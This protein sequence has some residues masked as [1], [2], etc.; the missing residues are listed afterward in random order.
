MLSALLASGRAV[1]I[2]RYSHVSSSRQTALPRVVCQADDFVLRKVCLAISGRLLRR[3]AN[4]DVLTDGIFL[5]PEA[6]RGGFADHDDGCICLL[7]LRA[8]AAPARDAQADRLEIIRG[9]EIVIRLQ[10]IIGESLL[11][12]N[13]NWR[14]LA[15][16]KWPPLCSTDALRPAAR[17][18]ARPAG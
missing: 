1:G 13:G 2:G 17:A 7:F 10:G 8:E 11:S 4:A 5:R 14:C 9:D 15:A 3:R 18:N 12:S 16:R 6:T